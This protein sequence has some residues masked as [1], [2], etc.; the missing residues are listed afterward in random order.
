[1]NSLLLRAVGDEMVG[2]LA[3]PARPI[4]DALERTLRLQAPELRGQLGELL[5]GLVMVA[6][7]HLR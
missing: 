5:H 7:Q 3:D 4:G 2:P 6:G 1:M